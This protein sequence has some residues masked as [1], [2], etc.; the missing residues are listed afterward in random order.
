MLNITIHRR[1]ASQKQ[2]IIPHNHKNDYYQKDNR[3]SCCGAAETNLTSSHADVGSL[4]SLAQ[5]VRDLA[6]P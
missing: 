2:K 1:N 4:P 6:L 3:N 5:W